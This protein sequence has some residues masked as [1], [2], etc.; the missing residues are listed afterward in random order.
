MSHYPLVSPVL[1]PIVVGSSQ[2]R[3][4]KHSIDQ[5]KLVKQTPHPAK[6]AVTLY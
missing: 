2:E 3:K 6:A 4:Q 1:I 5:S